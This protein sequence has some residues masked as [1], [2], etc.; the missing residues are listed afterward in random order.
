MLVAFDVGN[1][2]VTLGIFD[3]A[4]LQ[5]A[6]TLATD[7]R[8]TAEE[9]RVLVSSL[10]ADEGVPR[11]QIYGAAIA[12]VVPPL[13][14]TFEQ[15]CKRL[16][17]VTPLTIGTGTR[18]GIRIATHNPRELGTDRVV[19]AVAAHSLYEGPAIV[20]DF[21]TPTTFDVVDASGVYLGSVIAPGLG[22]SAEALFQNT[23]R[24]PRVDLVRPRSVVGKDTATALQSGLLFGHAALVDGLIV[25]IQQEIGQRAVVVATGEIAALIAAETT[26]INRVEPYLTLIGLRLLYELNCADRE[27]RAEN[28]TETRRKPR[29]TSADVGT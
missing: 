4:E 7:V 3:G 19:N 2:R 1:S 15:L 18:T 20:V 12:S 24:L 10:L 25:R 22:L 26:G 14:N 8:R 9:Y 16:F 28:S 29:R 27:T 11:E 5:A 17:G 23:S 6:F 13:T 21:G